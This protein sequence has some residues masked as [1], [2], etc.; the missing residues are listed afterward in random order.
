MFLP[1][2]YRC[3]FLQ[4]LSLCNL[5]P[6]LCPTLYNPKHC[7]PP[8]LTVCGILQERILEWVPLLQGIVFTQTIFKPMSHEASAVQAYGLPAE[9]AGKPLPLV[10]WV[11]EWSN[12][13][14]F[15]Y[16][17]QYN[18]Q[19]LGRG[20]ICLALVENIYSSFSVIVSPTNDLG[21]WRM[22]S[23]TDDLRSL[24]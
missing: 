6:P 7:N 10:S 20:V 16:I 24:L 9:P 1:L 3:K 15:Y 11:A 17:T 4:N 12:N 8:D 13:G 23:C 5:V 18:F 21:T 22:D 19:M 14:I 2:L